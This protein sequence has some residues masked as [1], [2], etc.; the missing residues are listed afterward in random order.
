M[1]VSLKELF[2][3]HSKRWKAPDGHLCDVSRGF[4]EGCVS[5]H[6]VAVVHQ[7]QRTFAIGFA[8]NFNGQ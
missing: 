2:I 4:I 6:D 3:A 1:N 5:N 8:F 7:I